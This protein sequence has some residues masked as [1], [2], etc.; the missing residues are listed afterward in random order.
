MGYS[1]E[2]KLIVYG[3]F[4]VTTL[5]RQVK[6]S[7]HT[8]FHRDCIDQ[9]LRAGNLVCPVDGAAI[10]TRKPSLKM[11]PGGERQ[12]ERGEKGPGNDLSL[13]GHSIRLPQITK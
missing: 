12:R 1:R 10:L 13:S 3:P 11:D 7:I 4:T 5:S 9:W 8:Q 6:I 2:V